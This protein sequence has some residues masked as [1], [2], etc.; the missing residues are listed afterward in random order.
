MVVSS[1]SPTAGWC[2]REW[3]SECD[4]MTALTGAAAFHSTKLV[5]SSPPV[6]LET[7]RKQ[8]AGR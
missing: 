5:L 8:G 4:P 3:A 7:G 6:A 2:E 1:W